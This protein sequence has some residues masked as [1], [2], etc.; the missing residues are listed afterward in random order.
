MTT[1]PVRYDRLQAGLVASVRAAVGEGPAIVWGRQNL[2]RGAAPAELVLLEAGDE[3]SSP[4]TA[5]TTTLPMIVTIRAPAAGWVRACGVR[6]DGADRDALVDA[7]AE[8]LPDVTVEAEGG[9]ALTLEAADVGDLYRLAVSEGFDLTV[10]TEQRAAVAIDL[11]V[12]R[13]AVDFYS[14]VTSPR[15]GSRR[16]ASRWRGWLGGPAAQ[17]LLA[18][19]DLAVNVVSM[20]PADD[21]SGPEHQ[22]RTRVSVDVS[23]PAIW[24]EAVGDIVTANMTLNTREPSAAVE[25]SIDAG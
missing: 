5:V 1:Q 2:P 4:D 10:D 7:L 20:L 6:F 16:T 13:V 19:H 12:V 11:A 24:A 9:D 15:A 21:F 23:M 8:G 14:Q 18:E 22:S 3:P 17:L 25:I